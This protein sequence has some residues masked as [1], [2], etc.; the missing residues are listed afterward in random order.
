M[1]KTVISASRRTDLPAFYYDWLQNVLRS[2]EVEQRNPFYRGS[3]YK[4]DLRPQAV[5]SIVLWSKDLSKVAE[6]PGCLVDYSLY[7]QYT[8]TGYSRVLEPNVP[9]Y[10]TTLGVLEKLLRRY[11]PRQF[12]I[13]FDPV[14]L[15]LQGEEAPI[16][17]KPGTARLKLFDRLCRDLKTLGMEGCRL[18]TSYIALYNHVAKRLETNRFLYYDIS[19]TLQIRFFTKLAEIA[20]RYGLA[21]YSCSSPILENIPGISSGRCID[22]YLLEALFGGKTSKAKDSGQRKTC[23]C[24]ASRDIGS[25]EQVCGHNCLYCYQRT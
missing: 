1:L 14:L 17:G 20:G 8:V 7:F 10:E 16:P 18:T 25:Y 3:T 12:T 13:R 15:S 9:S 22:G 19:E 2:G 24:T 23:G 6:E 4:V 5:H 11:D 21:L